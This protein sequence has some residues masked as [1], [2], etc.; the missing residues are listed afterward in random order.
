M[1][2]EDPSIR[3]RRLR[4][5]RVGNPVA[6]RMGVIWLVL[7]TAG[8]FVLGLLVSL[9]FDALRAI[10]LNAPSGTHVS[11]ISVPLVIAGVVTGTLLAG[12][13]LPAGA[14]QLDGYRA[15]RG[16]GGWALAIGVAG[17]RGH[18]IWLT[19]YSVSH[20]GDR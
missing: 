7:G 14:R 15:T 12:L 18:L 20:G 2:T 1:E 11:G 4:D 17:L 16:A 5:G 6:L 13:G 8:A 10:F 19:R 9:W 3:R